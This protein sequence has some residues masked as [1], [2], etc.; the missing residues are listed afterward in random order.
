MFYYVHGDFWT[1]LGHLRI[2]KNLTTVLENGNFQSTMTSREGRL[3]LRLNQSQVVNDLM[4]CFCEEISVKTQR[5][6]FEELPGWE[7]TRIREQ[8]GWEMTRTGGSGM[9]SEGTEA[10]NTFTYTL[11]FASLLSGCS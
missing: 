5:M 1:A 6:G 4:S 11:P 8:E 9:L 3:G 7:T 2:K 10:L